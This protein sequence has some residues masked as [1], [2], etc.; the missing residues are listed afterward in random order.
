MTNAVWL[1]LALPLWYFVTL[2]DPLGAGPLSAVPVFGTIC[3]VAGLI[4]GLSE[5]PRRLF[6]FLIP[7]TA[8]ELFVATAGAMRGQLPGE[9][10]HPALLLF[11]GFQVVFSGYLIYGLKGARWAAVALALFSVSYALFAAFVA[12]MAFSDR[13]L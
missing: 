4:L 3:L 9:S 5:R 13:W 8:S 7:A 12:A 10:S 6:L 11:I 2:G 1:L